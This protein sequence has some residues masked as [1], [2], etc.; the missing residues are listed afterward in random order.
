MSF[1][2]TGVCWNKRLN[3]WSVQIND[4]GKRIHIGYFTNKDDAII[5]RLKSE[6]KYYGEF[7]PQKH[8][9]NKYNIQAG[10]W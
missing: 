3:K 9:F 2:I 4:N 5:E 1:G 8:L 10:E 7:A 6:L